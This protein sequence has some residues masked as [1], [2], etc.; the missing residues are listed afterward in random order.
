MREY[1]IRTSPLEF[2]NILELQIE[3]EVNCHGKMVI[4]G[5][6]TDEQEEAYLGML[7]G[8]VW[9]QIRM[10]GRE[11]EVQILFYGIVTD[12]SVIYCNDQKKLTLEI[13]SGSVLMDGKRHLRSFQNPVMTYGQILKKIA[14]EY[15]E[16]G[17]VFN[18]PWEEQTGELVLQYYETDWEFFKRLASRKHQFLVP[19][20]QAKGVR[21]SYALPMGESFILSEGQKYTMRKD[22]SAY[23]K[24]ADQNMSVSESDCLEYMVESR[25]A[26]R[27]G[28]YTTLFGELFY[29]YQIK[30][31]YIGGELLHF[32]YMKRKRGIEVPEAFQEEMAGCALSATVTAVKEDKVQIVIEEDE[33]RQQEPAV[34]YPYATVYSTPDGTGWYCMPEPGDRVRLTV[35]E[36]WE[37]EAFVTSSV[38]VE[39]DSADRKN[40]DHKVFKSKYGKEVRFTP[41]SIVI[42]NNQGNRIEMTDAE[43]IHIVSAHS[44]VLEA[45]EDMTITSNAGSLLV[46]GASSVSFKQKGTSIELE[47]DISFVG[48]NLKIQ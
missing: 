7:T 29:I 25:E 5:Y 45:Q 8:E 24:K 12:F 15:R 18:E 35:P 10:I 39:T 47:N 42:T 48:G 2:L 33:N 9:E 4:S 27:I 21:L 41:D 38:H 26:R 34:W 31:R 14:E 11:G 40:P 43:G 22:L 16:S 46:A 44:V 36:K 32:C 30:S 13:M 3:E 28:D 17:I 1:N 6:I 19:D 20:A 37:K 23:R